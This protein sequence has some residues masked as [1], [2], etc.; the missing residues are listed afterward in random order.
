M[1]TIDPSDNTVAT[2]LVTAIVIAVIL[3]SA[4]RGK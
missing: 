4:P 3:V 2:L 1:P